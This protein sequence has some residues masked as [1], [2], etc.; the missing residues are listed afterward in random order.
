MNDT[1]DQDEMNNF[2]Q[3]HVANRK[4]FQTLSSTNMSLN[5]NLASC[6]QA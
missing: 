4:A 1:I 6:I 2:A 5:T 3:A